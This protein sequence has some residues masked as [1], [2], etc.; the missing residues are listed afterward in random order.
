MDLGGQ[1]LE[2]EPGTQGSLSQEG[3][4]R[5]LKG[6]T[7]KGRGSSMAELGLVRLLRTA[8]PISCL[9]ALLLRPKDGPNRD[10]PSSSIH[11]MELGPAATGEPQPL[12]E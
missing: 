11:P 7:W 10:R 6:V 4:G 2:L 3:A 5:E 12:G 9:L 8:V 1:E